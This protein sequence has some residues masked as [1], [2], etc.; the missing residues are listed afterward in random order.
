MAQGG[1]REHLTTPQHAPQRR[2]GPAAHGAGLGHA[3]QHRRH[4]EPLGQAARAHELRQ[5]VRQ[6]VDLRRHEVQLGARGQSPEHV[7][8]RQIEMERRMARMAVPGGRPEVAVRPLYET[9]HAGVADDHAL[10][11]TGGSRREEDMGGSA[12]RG[13][14]VPRPGWERLE[15]REHKVGANREVAGAALVHAA[16]AVARPRTPGH[17]QFSQG[18]RRGARDEHDAGLARREDRGHARRGVGGIHR[19]IDPASFEHTE[20]G[21]HGGRRFREEQGDALARPAP[22]RAEQPR[23]PIARRLELAVADARLAQHQRACVWAPLRLRRRPLV[24]QPRHGLTRAA[25]RSN[26]VRAWYRSSSAVGMSR[27]NASWPSSRYRAS[28]PATSS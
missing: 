21:D 19:H 10:G 24:Q 2:E 4:R 8:R 12:R 15:V 13:R 20:Q 16:D 7:V 25:A 14:R 9:D 5:F 27:M 22:D 6:Q 3:G 23:Q 11:N 18:A 28:S 1:R 17:A 26:A